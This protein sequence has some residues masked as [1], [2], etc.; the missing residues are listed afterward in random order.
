MR[1][2]LD[3]LSNAT[4]AMEVHSRALEAKLSESTKEINELRKSMESIRTEALT[5]ALTGVGNRKFFDDSIKL[6]AKECAS[7]AGT[8]SLLIGDVD[9]FKKFNDKWGHQT[10]DQVLRLVAS[11]MTSNVKGRDLVARYG[12][13]E[14]AILLPNTPLENAAKI[15]EQIRTSVEGKRLRKRSTNEDLGVI[16]LSIGVAQFAPNDTVGGLIER[17][18]QCLYIGK[19]NGRNRVIDE[20]SPDF[21]G[22]Q[23]KSVA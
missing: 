16:T 18:D 2:M 17:A 15:A 3:K 4:R 10:G 14:F 7:G 9:Y 1:S 23:A 22:A 5:D 8:F 20:R 11:C 19:R 12:G 13:E 21:V 6:L